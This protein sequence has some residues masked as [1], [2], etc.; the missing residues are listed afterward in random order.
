MYDG[1][2]AVIMSGPW[3]R[4]VAP[5]AHGMP[6]INMLDIKVSNDDSADRPSGRRM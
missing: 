5:L 4:S 6:D 1:V 3:V 2:G